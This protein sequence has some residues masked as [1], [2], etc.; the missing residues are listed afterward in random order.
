MTVHKRKTTPIPAIM[1]PR[2]FSSMEWAKSMTRMA[3]SCWPDN[4]FKIRSCSL[5]S[6]P[7][8]LAIPKAM[9]ATGTID[10][11]VYS[12]RAEALRLHRSEIKPRSARVRVRAKPMKSA[13]MRGS[14]S[15]FI[16]QMPVWKK[17]MMPDIEGLLSFNNRRMGFFI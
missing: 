4:S 1:P 10:S 15:I 7:N 6:N 14:S 2:V 12:V 9:A 17:S 13:L 8:P 5:F 16:C 11:S 3:T